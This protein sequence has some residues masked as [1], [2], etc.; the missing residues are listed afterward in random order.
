M[1]KRGLA[2]WVIS[3]GSAR[4][5]DNIVRECARMWLAMD[6]EVAGIAPG[7]GVAERSAR[8][9][10][11]RIYCGAHMLA[12]RAYFWKWSLCGSIVEVNM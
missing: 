11:C 5:L 4:L 10:V 1:S 12:T 7:G 8:A 6:Q 9:I 2:V 3:R